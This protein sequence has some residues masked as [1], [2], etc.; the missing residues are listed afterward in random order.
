MPGRAELGELESLIQALRV[1]WA[2][3]CLVWRDSAR[4]EFK[5]QFW[6]NWDA[7]LS[8]FIYVANEISD[9]VDDQLRKL[10]G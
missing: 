2:E 8:D 6:D 3:V 10:K 9:E 7:M 4:D 5:R 1:D